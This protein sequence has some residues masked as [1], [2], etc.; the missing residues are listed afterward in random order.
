MSIDSFKGYMKTFYNNLLGLCEAR[1]QLKQ[2]RY[3][4]Y[5]N[6]ASN[7][8]IYDYACVSALFD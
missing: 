2:F 1:N 8:I 3:F 4:S 7:L 5:C 6:Y